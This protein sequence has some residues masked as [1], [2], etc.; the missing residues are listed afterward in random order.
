[1]LCG[2]QSLSLFLCLGPGSKGARL[3]NRNV[4]SSNPNWWRIDSTHRRN[5]AD[6]KSESICGHQ[7]VAIQ[8]WLPYEETNLC[9]SNVEFLREA[10]G[11][12][13]FEL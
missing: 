8:Q 5:G 11:P 10:E 13:R 7:F 12:P 9:H 2:R 4:E 1:M 3:S 6:L